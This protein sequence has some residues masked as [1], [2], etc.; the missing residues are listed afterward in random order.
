MFQS[1]YYLNGFRGAHVSPLDA[2]PCIVVD[3]AVLIGVTT[4]VNFNRRSE[5]RAAPRACLRSMPNH[6]LVRVL[7]D[8]RLVDENSW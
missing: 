5:H 6:R 7:V 3:K 1:W 8:P 2:V 4:K